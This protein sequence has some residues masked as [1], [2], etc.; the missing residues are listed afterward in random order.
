MR[1]WCGKGDG[2]GLNEGRRRLRFA[3]LL[4]ALVVLVLPGAAQA[5]FPG[6]NGKIAFV[7]PGDCL[8]TVNPDGTG[9]ALLL[10]CAPASFGSPQATGT[11]P[12]F[13]PDGSWV[14]FRDA[15]WGWVDEVR[16]DGTQFT[17]SIA[18]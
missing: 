12:R 16:S 6:Q 10:T 4:A 11:T 2:M 1:T 17:L 9:E 8:N 7:K 5:A 3:A 14:V 18:D 13:S 15:Y